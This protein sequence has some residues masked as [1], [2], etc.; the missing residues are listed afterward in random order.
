MR[1]KLITILTILSVSCGQG[2]SKTTAE[3]TGDVGA[4]LVDGFELKSDKTLNYNM[5][6]QEF[7]EIERPMELPAV[8]EMVLENIFDKK[9]ELY[10]RDFDKDRIIN[11]KEIINN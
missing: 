11:N 9:M 4:S 6:T 1:I 7:T 2:Q 10:Y 8:D 5:D 3:E